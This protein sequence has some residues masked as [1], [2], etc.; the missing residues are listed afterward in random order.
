MRWLAMMLVA[1]L[2]GGCALTTSTSTGSRARLYASVEELSQDSPLIVVGTSSDPVSEPDRT[3]STV[4]ITEV[5]GSTLTE[6]P[7]VGDTVRV[8]QVADPRLSTDTPYL[9]FLTP[10]G[11]EP[12]LFSSGADHEYYVVGVTAGLWLSTGSTDSFERSGDEGDTLPATL[13][14]D[15]L[16]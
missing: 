1:G 10:T 8:W 5:I 9:L 11:L 16:R 14:L 3:G 6:A 13:N 15:E 7:A 4:T 2:L 12:T